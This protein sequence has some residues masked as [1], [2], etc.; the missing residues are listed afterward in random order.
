MKH[1]INFKVNGDDYSLAVDPWRTLNELLREDLNL[2][3]TK[4]GCGTGDCGACTVMVDDRTVSSCLTLA[5][6]VD[7]KML[8]PWRGSLLR[9]KSFT[10]YR[11]LL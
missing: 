2:T 10:P 6:S 1:H 7:G 9:A 3:G 11:M 5:V 8:Q 4:L